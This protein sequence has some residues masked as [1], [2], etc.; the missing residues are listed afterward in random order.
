MEQRGGRYLRLSWGELGSGASGCCLC[1]CF[2][3]W[4]QSSIFSG[5]LQTSQTH[6]SYNEE[7]DEDHCSSPGGTPASKSRLC[8]HSHA[9]GDHSQVFLQALADNS[10]QDHNVKVRHP[11]GVSVAQDAEGPAPPALPSAS[12]A[13]LTGSGR[14]EGRGSWLHVPMG[15]WQPCWW[16]CTG[17]CLGLEP[18]RTLCQLSP[19]S[20]LWQDFL[21]QVERCCRQCHLTTP[22]SFPPE[23][24]VEEV[25]RLLLCCLLKHEDLGRSCVFAPKASD[26]HVGHN[27]PTGRLVPVSPGHVAL[28]LA[29]AS[30]LS[31]EQAKH[32]ALPKSVVDVCRV[33]YQ[34]KCSLIK[35]G[36]S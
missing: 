15:V 33:V 7:K 35:V 8:A 12:W 26:S 13:W 23:H 36:Q 2:L 6:Y 18:R 34:A 27:C 1:V 31:V 5:G 28:S 24:P 9:L 17:L 4:L 30:T 16:P 11:Q 20:G 32:R 14:V 3:E 21:C 22:I 19:L 25:G 29:H 10:V